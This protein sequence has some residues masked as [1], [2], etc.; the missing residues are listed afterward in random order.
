MVARNFDLFY[1]EVLE[2]EGLFYEDVPGDNGGPTKCGITIA[3]VARW[4]G[5]RCPKRG[6]AG[7]DELVDKVRALTPAS[8]R[9]IYKK[10]YWD[11][12]RADELPAGLDYCVVD[13]AVNSGTGR[14]IPTLG[15]LLGM[16]GVKTI[17]DEV[18]EAVAKED[19]KDL[20]NR[21]QD[22]RRRFLE[23]ISN[24]PGQ[25]KFRKGWLAREARVR[26]TSLALAA[27]P[28][29]STRMAA[30]EMVPDVVKAGAQSRTVWTLISGG[31]LQLIQM[32]TDWLEH[33]W[34]TVLS[35]IGLLPT[36]TGEVKEQAD[37]VEQISTWLKFD[38]KVAAVIVTSV[39]V[40]GIV[41]AVVRHASD[42]HALEVS[43]AKQD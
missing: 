21:Y 27:Q 2:S 1:K 42:K 32:C 12:V 15:K 37:S 40:V 20:I 22:E 36:V 31:V 11:S 19:I 8:S 41:V 35:V 17:T 13:Y 4:N 26:K 16:S 30:A 43:N 29:P 9:D 6:G 34:N 25:A 3:D 5:V 33:A 28:A 39:V 7:W 18:L 23:K 24:N 14:A 10:F 38:P